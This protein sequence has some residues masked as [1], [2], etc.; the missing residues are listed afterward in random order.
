MENLDDDHLIRL[1]VT[2]DGAA[3]AVLLQEAEPRLLRFARKQLSRNVRLTSAPED[4]VQET[5]LEATRLI[6]HFEPRG[7]RAFYAW[8]LRILRL[9]I[10]AAVQKHL[11]RVRHG[12]AA[13]FDEDSSVINAIEEL[14]IY[15]R[16]PSKS[17]AAHEFIVAVERSLAT[18]PDQYR[19]VVTLRHL[20]GLSVEETAARMGK[21]RATVSVLTSRALAALRERLKSESRY[22]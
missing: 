20:D 9:R 3:L 22:A 10:R 2:G 19:Q 1:A 21:D 16:T 14:A 17:A 5:C 8:L 18:M 15:R 12:T 11:I 4:V 7:P 6:S 13:R